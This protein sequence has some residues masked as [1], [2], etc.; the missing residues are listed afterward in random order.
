M[1]HRKSRQRDVAA[2]DRPHQSVVPWYH[3]ER[4]PGSGRQDTQ[5]QVVSPSSLPDDAVPAWHHPTSRTYLQRRGLS[6]E[7]AIFYDLHFCESGSFGGRVVIPVYHTDTLLAYQGRSIT[8]G[9]PRYLTVGP[10]PLYGPFGDGEIL[11]VVEGPFDCFAVAP[12]TTAVALLGMNISEIQLQNLVAI[13]CT[14]VA[15]WFDQELPALLAANALV[16]TLSRWKPTVLVQGMHKDPA[17]TPHREIQ[18]CLQEMQA[19]M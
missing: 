14:Q 9:T 8:G 3:H 11:V 15:V 16:A 7:E 18:Q 12:V 13:T 17:D 5:Q 1:G 2:L 4:H 19:N 10:R 6:E